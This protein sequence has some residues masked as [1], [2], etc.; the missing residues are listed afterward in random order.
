MFVNPRWRVATALVVLALCAWT[1]SRGW[2]IVRF[3]HARASM[4]S[5]NERANAVAP[6][7]AVSGIAGAAREAAL[8]N[9]EPND[10]DSVRK[11]GDEIAAILSVRPISSI[12]WLA[13]A[14]LRLFAGRPPDD[15]L[16]ALAMSSL[17]GPNEGQALAQRGIFGLWQWENLPSRVGA[18]LVSGLAGAIL[19]RATSDQERATME[20]MLAA[21]SAQARREI[22]DVFRAAG[23]SAADLG[24]LGLQSQG[25][26]SP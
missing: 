1:A 3:S 6:W 25:A 5:Q 23:L 12:N 16:G 19:A 21:K 13:L 15:V 14:S 7:L 18:Q 10:I 17:T 20:R 2:A 4:T 11:R 8:T 9:A 22:A 24:R 26:A